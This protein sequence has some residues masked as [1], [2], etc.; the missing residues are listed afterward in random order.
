MDW[1][2]RSDNEFSRPFTLLMISFLRHHPSHSVAD[3]GCGLW[4]VEWAWWVPFLEMYFFYLQVAT[5]RDR[6]EVRIP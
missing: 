4:V 5:G 6:V 1:H 2:P 3:W